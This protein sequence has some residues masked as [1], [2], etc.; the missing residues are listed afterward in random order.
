MKRRSVSVAVLAIVTTLT[1][2]LAAQQQRA[3]APPSIDDRTSGMKKM[4]GLFP[5]YW[6]ERTGS[7]FMEVPYFNQDFLFSNGLSAGLGSN[8]VGLDRGR[9]GQGRV[10]QFQRVGPRVFLVQ[11]NQSFRS[12][13]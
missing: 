10:V 7:M 13:R 1:I 6:D 8:D 3:A 2:P 11:A 4:D 5:L 9:G 12:S